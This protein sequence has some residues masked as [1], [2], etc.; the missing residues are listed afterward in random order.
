M[1]RKTVVVEGTTFESWPEHG[2]WY[3]VGGNGAR[4][5]LHMP[6]FK[7]GDPDIENVSEIEVTYE[8]A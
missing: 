1:D 5:T 2:A 8:E 3:E 7:G 6:M 4:G